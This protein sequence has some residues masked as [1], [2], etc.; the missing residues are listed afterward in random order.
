MEEVELKEFKELLV[1]DS[2]MLEWDSRVE[3]ISA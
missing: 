1:H 2:E 3:T